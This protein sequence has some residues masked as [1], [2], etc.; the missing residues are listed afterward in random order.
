MKK[1]YLVEHNTPNEGF[2]GY[3]ITPAFDIIDKKLSYKTVTSCVKL[4]PSMKRSKIPFSSRRLEMCKIIIA[5]NG[6]L[7]TGVICETDYYYDIDSNEWKL[8]DENKKSV[9]HSVNLSNQEEYT[10]VECFEALK[11]QRPIAAQEFL[12]EII[13]LTNMKKITITSDFDANYEMIQYA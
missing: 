5:D 3:C 2:L 8:F 13:K 11:N 6:L 10:L 9:K 7:P 1:T 12:D 4:P